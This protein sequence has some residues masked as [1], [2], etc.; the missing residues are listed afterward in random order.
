MVFNTA[1]H[2]FKNTIFSH[3]KLPVGLRQLA[4][5][6][7]VV[8]LAA[9]GTAEKED[10]KG[11]IGFVKGFLGG[12]VA[13]EPRAA[14]IGRDVLS[15]GG[16]AADAVT[17]MYFAASVTM[18]S[19]ASLGG[20]GVCI[21][22][23]NKD[24]KTE[25][26]DFLSKAPKSIPSGVERPT[27]V[28][29]NA[30][31]FFILQSRYGDLRWGQLVAPAENLARFGTP[32]SRA[33]AAELKPV[34]NA[35]IR[36]KEAAR[37]F[38]KDNGEP[39]R[40]GDIIK[41]F[42]LAA[43]LTEIRSKGPG[44]LYTGTFANRFVEAVNAAGGHLTKDDLRDAL[45]VWRET[46]KSLPYDNKIA[47][48]AQPAASGGVVGAQMWSMMAEYGDLDGVDEAT[49][50]HVLAEVAMRAYGDR[51]RWV[52]PNGQSRVLSSTLVTEDHIEKLMSGMSETRH[53]AA[54][55]LAA[56]PQ[57]TPETP[58]ALSLAAVDRFGS[59]VACNVS[60]N[61]S[62][63]VGRFAPGTGVLLSALPGLNGRGPMPLGPM[64][65]VNPNSNEVYFV[66]AASRGVTAPTQLVNVASRI[67]MAGEDTVDAISKA[68]T[69]HGGAPDTLYYEKGIDTSVLGALQSKGHQLAPVQG[70]GIVNAIA[71]P[72]GLPVKPESCRAVNDPRGYGLAVGAD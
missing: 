39:V 3:A 32:V 28:P 33:L 67:I 52:L 61:N 38:A 11:K 27:G 25:T 54:A 23:D 21:I 1:Y 51:A 5:C 47:H 68:R 2:Q 22:H 65:V 16:T 63:G 37:V 31:G 18:P 41:Q 71:C 26:L 36:D 7:I 62:F 43:T 50:A 72:L 58:S 70:L 45:P 17:A 12:V 19:S 56:V 9:C 20:G 34:G 57:E 14:L 53:Q 10:D 29:M 60:M 35:L 59:A 40:E 24:E 48:F 4:A 8:S 66:G 46:V 15:A 44:A 30:R 13:D 42:D 69:H 64:V 55:T 49:K 6:A